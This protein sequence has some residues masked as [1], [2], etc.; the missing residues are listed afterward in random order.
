MLFFFFP[1]FSSF[2]SLS[3]GTHND[4]LC[5]DKRANYDG[6]SIEVSRVTRSLSPEGDGGP[7]RRVR[8]DEEAGV[9]EEEIRAKRNRNVASKRSHQPEA[10]LLNFDQVETA[11]ARRAA[12][13]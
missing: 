12:Q 11:D 1:S 8:R 6:R 13:K 5:A 2:S 3:S 4:K 10:R 9:A 7:D